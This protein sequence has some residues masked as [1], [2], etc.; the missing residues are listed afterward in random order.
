MDE[1]PYIPWGLDPIS[2]S[3]AIA[4]GVATEWWVGLGAWAI[5]TAMFWVGWWWSRRFVPRDDHGQ[6]S[7]LRRRW[8]AVCIP[9]LAAVLPG[10]V[11][12][13]ATIRWNVLAGAVMGLGLG[14]YAFTLQWLTGRRERTTTPIR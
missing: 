9:V 14:V 10:V 3:T 6:L 11:I 13:L 4:V 1:K 12:V 5:W 7:Y 2:V 8:L